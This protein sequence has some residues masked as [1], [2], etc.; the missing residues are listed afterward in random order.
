MG[1][2]DR[3][4]QFN[5]ESTSVTDWSLV[6]RA[7]SSDQHSSLEKLLR[8][9][10]PPLKMYLTRHRHLPHEAADE[11]I[12]EFVLERVLEKELL[13]KA[14]RSRG[15]FRSFLLA[16]LNHFLI[17][18]WRKDKRRTVHFLDNLDTVAV[19]PAS[20]DRFDADWATSILGESIRRVREYFADRDE[21]G[22]WAVFAHRTVLP[23]LQGAKPRSYAELAKQYRFKDAHEARNRHTRAKRRFRV[24]VVDVIQQYALDAAEIDREVWDLQDVLAKNTSHF[25][26][27]L[28]QEMLVEL[29]AGAFVNKSSPGW[30]SRISQLFLLKLS[31]EHEPND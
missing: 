15:K 29:N 19:E 14:D 31:D 1:K 5:D 22:I 16:S 10:L 4:E 21:F 30:E 20:Q 26:T 12:N 7:A 17:D 27:L 3:P 11:L 23:A 2:M 6:R 28:S 9:Y 18:K 13:S 25:S 8:I 24:V